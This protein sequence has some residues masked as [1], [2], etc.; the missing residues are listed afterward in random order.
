MNSCFRT[1]N[2]SPEN[3]EGFAISNYSTERTATTALLFAGKEVTILPLLSEPDAPAPV[4]PPNKCE[5]D[6]TAFVQ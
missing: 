6:E 5:N 3:Q 1:L 4:E 2:L